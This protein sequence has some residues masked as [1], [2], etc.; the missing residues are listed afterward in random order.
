MA[1]N[2]LA[3]LKS[4]RKTPTAIFKICYY[5]FNPTFLRNQKGKL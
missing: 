5:Y 2:E 3:A 4:W 1:P